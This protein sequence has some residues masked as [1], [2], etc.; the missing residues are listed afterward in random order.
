MSSDKIVIKKVAIA[1]ASGHL[2]RRV[3]VA[4]LDDGSFD[5][6]VLARSGSSSQYPP[7]AQVVTVD[8]GSPESLQAA[9]EGIDAVVSTLG[10]KNGLECQFK[11]VDAA[12]AS[13]VQRFI[14]SEFGADLQNPKIRAFP[15]YRSKVQVEDYLE[16]QASRTNLTYSY[17][18]NSMLFDDGLALG[19]FGD[20]TGRTM[21]IY[22]GGETTFSTTR[23]STVAQAVVAT[24]RNPQETKNRAIRIT[25]LSTTPC[26]L[27]SVIERLDSG[28]EWSSA[29]VDT[30]SLVK[31]VENELAC[32]KFSPKA[33]AAFAT[34]GTFAPGYAARYD[35]DN[36]LLGINKMSQEEL[37]NVLR[38]R[39]L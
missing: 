36:E 24:L 13:G 8:Y 26:A 14:P 25:D 39:L 10:K 12:V 2:G 33:F 35:G 21:N 17:V 31:E 1:G 20:F 30:E 37:E 7:R 28:H 19:V 32:E 34:K 6:I 18:Y 15:T 9:L 23:I 11:L 22:D 5:V 29:I 27:L 16:E 3:L 38:S 4:L